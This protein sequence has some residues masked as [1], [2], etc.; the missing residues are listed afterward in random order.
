MVL[1]QHPQALENAIVLQINKLALT[2]I[3]S[4]RE[5]VRGGWDLLKSDN[6]S[7]VQLAIFHSISLARPRTRG[8]NPK[9][10][11]LLWPEIRRSCEIRRSSREDACHNYCPCEYHQLNE[12][13][14]VSLWCPFCCKTL[15]A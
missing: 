4:E 10:I 15:I 6:V 3:S 2:G 13:D 11:E 12:I 5:A 14:V 1:T 7:F 8:L 9:S